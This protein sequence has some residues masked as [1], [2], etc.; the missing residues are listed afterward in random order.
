MEPTLTWLDF[1]ASDRDKMRRV[2]DLL[3]EHLSMKRVALP[4]AVL[5]F[6]DEGP[7]DQGCVL[8]RK[9]GEIADAV[10]HGFL[11]NEA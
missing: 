5:V 9:V 4:L 6:G 7:I 11:Q 10:L 8:L 2:L 3:G 1:T